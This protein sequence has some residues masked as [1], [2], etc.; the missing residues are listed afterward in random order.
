MENRLSI[1]ILAAGQGTRMRSK[2]PKVLHTIGNKPLIAHVIETSMQLSPNDIHIV[3]GYGGDSVKAA[4]GDPQIHWCLQSQQLGTGHAVREVL[5][6]IDPNDSVLVLYGDMPLIKKQ[7]LEA[8]LTSGESHM[9][10]LLSVVLD[11]PTGY[12]RIIRDSNKKVQRIVEES[13]ATVAEKGIKEVN[14][15]FIVAR[16]RDLKRWLDRVSNLNVQGEYYLTDC[17]ENAV[18]EGHMV[19]AVICQ[20]PIEVLGI[21]DKQQLAECERIYQRR[22]ANRLMREGVT[23]R[24]PARLDVRGELTAGRDV[25]IDVNVVFEGKVELGDDV[26][27]GPNCV[28]RDV[29]IGTGSEIMPNCVIEHAVIGARCQIGPFTRIRPETRIAD[30]VHLGNFV[31]VKKS[32]IDEATKINHLSYVG[33]SEI[34]KRVNVGA[35][36]ITCNY[37]GAYKH[38]TQ[39]GDDVFIGSN[40]QLIAPVTVGEGATIGAGST[41]TRDAP[42]QHLTLSRSKQITIEGWKRPRKSK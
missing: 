21:N 36:T 14:T 19:N 7:T 31:E 2:A 22:Q 29:V 39:I 42:E 18:R 3:Y 12:G 9:L 25:T 17:T 16:A 24:D 27:I 8:L 26:T 33:D 13:D 40:T 6:T 37:D 15:G 20:N 32:V 30:E 28:V 5:P 4:I 23:L 10:S 35:G 34:G 41:I 1:V 11:N 38:K